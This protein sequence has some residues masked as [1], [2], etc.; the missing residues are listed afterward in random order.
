MATTTTTLDVK[1]MSCSHCVQTIEKAL[2]ELQGVS[3]VYVDLNGNKVTVSFDDATVGLDKI[4][5]TIED[6]GYEV[7]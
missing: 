1:G 5:E 3:A 2:G 4:K 7:A 6:V